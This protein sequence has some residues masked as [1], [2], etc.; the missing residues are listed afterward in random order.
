MERLN[1][2]I[3][4]IDITAMNLVLLDGSLDN[5]LKPNELKSL[6]MNENASID[7][8]LAILTDRKVKSRDVS[9]RFLVR[10]QSQIDLVKKVESL[11][12]FLTKGIKDVYGNY[13]GENRFHIIELERV[14]RLVFLKCDKYD[15]FGEDSA[16]LSLQFKELNPLNR[17]L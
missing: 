5:L 16:I 6:V 8:S 3:N 10:S 1:I 11:T 12:D 9:V 13:S 15:G 14:Y 4:G 7:G 2:S 17:S